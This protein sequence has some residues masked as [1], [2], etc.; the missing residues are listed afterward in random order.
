MPLK[1]NHYH[2]IYSRVIFGI[3]RG[4]Y[5]FLGDDDSGDVVF[6]GFKC[7]WDCCFVKK[8]DL[9]KNNLCTVSRR[10]KSM[11]ED[12]FTC[13]TCRRIDRKK[14]T[15]PSTLTIPSGTH[16]SGTIYQRYWT[17]RVEPPP[18]KHFSNVAL[19]APFSGSIPTNLGRHK[20]WGRKI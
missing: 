17:H 9:G 2:A 20:K 5:M 4:G 11:D 8:R 1:M 18:L 19:T 3:V 6:F 16:L 13:L 10:P 7:D 12:P 14:Q 15:K